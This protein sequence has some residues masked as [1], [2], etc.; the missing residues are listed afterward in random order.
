M[1]NYGPM[2]GKKIGVVA[3]LFGCGHKSLSR[4]FSH[5]SVGYR[6][7]LQCGARKKFDLETR[8]TS[9]QTYYPPVAS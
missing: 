3:G 6:T 9:T 8:T 1:A 5:G 2:F 7:C 4:P